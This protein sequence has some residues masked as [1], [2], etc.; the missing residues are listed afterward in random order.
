MHG[1][2]VSARPHTPDAGHQKPPA[3][4]KQSPFTQKGSLRHLTAV[5]SVAVES[6]RPRYCSE[7][8]ARLVLATEPVASVAFVDYEDGIVI[9]GE[10]SLR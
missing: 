5:V 3:R 4:V 10:T 6:P 2:T 9:E 8:F 7:L 1:A